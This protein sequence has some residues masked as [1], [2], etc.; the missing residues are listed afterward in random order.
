[1]KLEYRKIISQIHLTSMMSMNVIRLSLL[2][3]Y[4]ISI[5]RKAFGSLVPSHSNM[6]IS[7]KIRS[8]QNIRFSISQKSTHIH[9]E[10]ELCILFL[11]THSTINKMFYL[12]T[13]C[14]NKQT[15]R[16]FIGEGDLMLEQINSIKALFKLSHING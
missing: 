9:A 3:I 16:E 4:F 13:C 10:S 15:N 6:T 11:P 5:F 12:W 1:M 7:R 14:N 8:S 2:K